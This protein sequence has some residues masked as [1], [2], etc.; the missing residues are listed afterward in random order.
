[1][2][3]VTTGNSCVGK[4]TLVR[5]MALELDLKVFDVDA[6]T[7]DQ[8]KYNE[9]FKLKLRERFGSAVKADIVKY[10][11][12]C[13][14]LTKRLAIN[15]IIQNLKEVFTRDISHF[16][17]AYNQHGIID[18]AQF[19]ENQTDILEGINHIVVCVT[20]SEEDRA[21]M[22]AQRNVDLDIMD[23]IQYSPEVKMV[24]S[25]VV[26]ENDIS[27][28]ATVVIAP[29]VAIVKDV[30]YFESAIT[31]YMDIEWITSS[32][33]FLLAFRYFAF[34]VCCRYH[35]NGMAHH[36]IDHIKHMVC[37]I[38]VVV[39]NY[40]RKVLEL[41]V[42]IMCHDMVYNINSTTNEADSAAEA[43]RMIKRY[44]GDTL[45]PHPVF[46]AELILATKW[47]V[48]ASRFKTESV[49][50]TQHIQD[51][52]ILVFAAPYD[53]VVRYDDAIC[54]E[55]AGNDPSR[56]YYRARIAFLESVLA[57]QV[58]YKSPLLYKEE[59]NARCNI[60]RM[61]RH[62]TEA[63]NELVKFIDERMDFE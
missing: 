8:Y 54:T 27:Q 13:D 38:P 24:M 11:N 4:S 28:Y 51:L 37:S 63:L 44:F 33:Q 1:M 21:C 9:Q 16:L 36:N 25:D 59:H 18:M 32:P 60:Q 12:Q 43:V 31:E 10:L 41:V 7:A 20:A 42:A 34:E 39:P 3:L 19:H 35:Q 26:L 15:H 45:A 61:I 58:I 23:K 55:Y 47:G 40:K 50:F 29:L 14:D 6:W 56:E 48:G 57:L 62:N 52:D 2:L 22:A 49:S 46:V 53:E 30:Q 5:Q 17:T